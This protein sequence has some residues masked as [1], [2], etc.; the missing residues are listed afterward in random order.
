MMRCMLALFTRISN[1]R[2]RVSTLRRYD[3][4]AGIEDRAGYSEGGHGMADFDPGFYIAGCACE[5]CDVCARYRAI[6]PVR[7]L[8]DLEGAMKR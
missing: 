1:Q 7:E 3:L 4:A 5:S 8:R 6:A 2:D